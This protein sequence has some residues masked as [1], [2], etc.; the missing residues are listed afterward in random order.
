MAME[1]LATGFWHGTAG[2]V[3]QISTIA[4]M[5]AKLVSMAGDDLAAFCVPS[6]IDT[7]FAWLCGRKGLIKDEYMVLDI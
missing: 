5:A 1:N 6:S 2:L 7:A 4:A 3:G